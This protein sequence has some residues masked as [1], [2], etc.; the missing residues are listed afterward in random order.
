MIKRSSVFAQ[1]DWTQNPTYV[2]TDIPGRDV[3]TIQGIEGIVSNI[4]NIIVPIVG[5]VL[6]IMLIV[7]GFQYIT[8]GGEAEQTAKAKKTLTT[9]LLGLL[10]VLGAWLI[11]KLIEE[12]TGLNLHEF[13]VPINEV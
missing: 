2:P 4:L 1:S 5:V 6:L 10:V 9:T 3:P 11:I 13:T 7:G 12:F 8:S